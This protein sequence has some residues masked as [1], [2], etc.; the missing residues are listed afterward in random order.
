MGQSVKQLQQAL[1]NAGV[2]V[3]GGVDGFFGLGTEGAVKAFQQ[4]K[5]L[6]VTGAVG[7]QTAAALSLGGNPAP[8]P[9]VT[10]GP[11]TATIGLRL[12]SHGPAVVSLQQA[13]QR[14]GWT[15]RGGADGVFGTATQSVLLVA[16]RSNGIRASGTVDEATAR[17]LGL[18]GSAPAA[19]PAAP[20]PATTAAGFANYDERGARV[21]AL[22]TALIRAGIAVPGGADGMFGASAGA[23]MSFQRARGLKVSGK[24]D[25]ATAAA[26]GLTAA[27]A[28]A[29]APAVNVQLEAKPVQG[30]CYYGDTWSAARGNGRVHL[31]VDIAAAEGK[32]LYAVA[33]GTMITIYTDSPGSLSG[34]GLKIARADGT[35]FF[36]AHLSQLAPGIALGKADRHRRTGRRVCRAHRQRRRSAPPPRSPPGRRLGRQP[37]SDREG[38]RSLLNGPRGSFADRPGD[39]APLSIPHHFRH[40]GICLW[41]PNC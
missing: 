24:V 30:P 5:G 37:V 11:A 35:Y 40:D 10:S 2:N 26:L 8:Q 21:V 4:S 22:Q 36:Y 1:I 7:P 16:Q 31:G 14:M 9:A 18:T 34:N 6:S 15:L 3:P 27:P 17:L 28:P 39:G 29:A 20:A 25:D 38:D 41:L 19:A 33:T 23:I 32:Q 12:G 13:L